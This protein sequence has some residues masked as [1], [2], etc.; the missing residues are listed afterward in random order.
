M[1]T[2]L[3]NQFFSAYIKAAAAANK[4]SHKRLL[5]MNWTNQLRSREKE[6]IQEGQNRT[7]SIA[8]VFHPNHEKHQQQK[9][10]GQARNG[11]QHWRKQLNA[12]AIQNNGKQANRN[13]DFGALYDSFKENHSF[14]RTSKMPKSKPWQSLAKADCI[15]KVCHLFP[16]KQKPE[17]LPRQNKSVQTGC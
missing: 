11:N 6:M 1:Y 12:N 7:H 17:P 8:S 15:S 5:K 16:K 9:E 2:K 14:T 3:Q 10:Q 13:T 4:K